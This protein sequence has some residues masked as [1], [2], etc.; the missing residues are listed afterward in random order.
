[1]TSEYYHHLES[2]EELKEFYSLIRQVYI[3]ENNYS[4]DAPDALAERAHHFA[5]KRDGK[6]VA[7]YRIHTDITAQDLDCISNIKSLLNPKW[8]IAELS[9][10]AIHPKYRNK[11][12]LQKTF[13]DVYVRGTQLGV[14]HFLAKA[15]LDLTNFYHHYGFHNL[16]NPYYD[17][18]PFANKPELFASVPNFRLLVV[19]NEE[20]KK[21][22]FSKL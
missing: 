10:W 9:R 20:L 13:A 7:C 18:K 14:T 19:E 16:G 15:I 2:A 3:E 1:M 6:I 5:I 11:I 21:R 22:F 4:I 17:S 8:K 12:S